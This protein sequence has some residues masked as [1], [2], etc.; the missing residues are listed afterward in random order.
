[1]IVLNVARLLKNKILDLIP[2]CCA[3][4]NYTETYQTFEYTR[5]SHLLAKLAKDP[6]DVEFLGKFAFTQIFS[7]SVDKHIDSLQKKAS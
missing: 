2:I 1:M 3:E 6:R 4:L 7:L 5:M